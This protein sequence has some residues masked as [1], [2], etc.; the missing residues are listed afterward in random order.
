M[1]PEE[2]AQIVQ[3][4]QTAL[5]ALQSELAVLEDK[6]ASLKAA[7]HENDQLRKM[8]QDNFAAY[9]ESSTKIWAMKSDH[10]P[11]LALLMLEKISPA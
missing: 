7:L 8:V 6:V 10:F 2:L 5:S 9:Q 4:T 11:D 1:T 3:E